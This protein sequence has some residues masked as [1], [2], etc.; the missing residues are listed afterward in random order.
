MFL[1]YNDEHKGFQC[2]DPK[3]RWLWTSRNPVFLERVSFHSSSPGTNNIQVSYLPQFKTPDLP[4]VI[5]QVY[6]RRPKQQ[7]PTAS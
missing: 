4:P 5:T 7:P 3:E 1:G 2:Y 6:T